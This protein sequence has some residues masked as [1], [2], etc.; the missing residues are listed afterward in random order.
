MNAIRKREEIENN[1][2]PV[3]LFAKAFIKLQAEIRP[4]V[5]DAENEAFKRGGKASKYADLGAVW[6]AVKGPLH[7]NGFAL[8]QSPDFDGPEM[9][10]ETILLHDSGTQVKGRYPLR[11]SKQDPQGYGSA[12]TYARRYSICAM[13]GVIAD[14]DDDGNAASGVGAKAPV[15]QGN[16]TSEQVEQILAL[17]KSTKTDIEKFCAYFKAESVPAIRAADFDRAMSA[18]RSKGK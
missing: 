12:L 17:I 18:L 10:L 16:V 4:A 6:E 1:A 9:W 8:I 3:D 7:D 2:V 14:E 13:L 11:P 15:P 5:K